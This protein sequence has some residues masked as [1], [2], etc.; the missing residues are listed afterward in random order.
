MENLETGK[1]GADPRFTDQSRSAKLQ[2]WPPAILDL[3]LL[4]ERD[5][6]KSRVEPS[7][8]TSRVSIKWKA[9]HP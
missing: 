9:A 4:E 6:R 2:K 7:S 5:F 8:R 1:I 3:A